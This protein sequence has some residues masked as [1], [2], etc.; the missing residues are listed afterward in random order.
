MSLINTTVMFF[1]Q[2]QNKET[3]ALAALKQVEIKNES[4]LEDY[5]VEIDILNECKHPNIVSLYEAYY[6]EGKL[7]VSVQVN[8]ETVCSV[9]ID[10][11]T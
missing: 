8:H 11:Y 7:W 4:E 1:V 9:G 5:T 10:W 2:A 3:K 6:F